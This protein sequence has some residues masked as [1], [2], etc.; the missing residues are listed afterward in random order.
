MVEPILKKRKVVLV[1]LHGGTD[2]ESIIWSMMK[3]DGVVSVKVDVPKNSTKLEYD[4]RKIKFVEVEDSFK[5]LGL[6]L[7]HSF[8][9]RLK[10]GMVNYAE[11]NELDN[12]NAPLSSCCDDPKDGVRDCN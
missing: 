9:A 10:R 4:L 2:I 5:K 12:L 8:L 1:N 11:Q 3:R 7:S 6:K